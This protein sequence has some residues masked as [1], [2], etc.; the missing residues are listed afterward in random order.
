MTVYR[1]YRNAA[2]RLCKKLRQQYYNKQVS[3][4]RQSDPSKWWENVKQFVGP[5]C[6]GESNE[7][8]GMARDLYDGDVDRMAE[9]INHFFVNIA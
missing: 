1:K 8:E 7:L 5:T 4:L 2:Q 9:Y 6:N 3:R